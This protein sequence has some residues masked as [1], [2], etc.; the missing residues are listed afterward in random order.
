MFLISLELARGAKCLIR[1]EGNKTII[2]R[3]TD[4]TDPGN[5]KAAARKVE[6]DVKAFTFNKSYWS[7]DK[8]DPNY[9]TQA[10]FIT[11]LEKIF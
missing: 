9:A 10:H 4:L 5:L 6:E 3:P 1:M 7:F 8:N 11:T 2:T